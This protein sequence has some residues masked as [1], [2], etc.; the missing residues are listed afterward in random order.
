MSRSHSALGIALLIALS[1]VSVGS[2][3][4][5]PAEAGA[6]LVADSIV[7]DLVFQ[8]KYA[9]AAYCEVGRVSLTWTCVN[10]LCG[11]ETAGTKVLAVLEN[12]LRADNYGGFL[13]L[14]P[15]GTTAVFSL[16]GSQ[17]TTDWVLDAAILP[18]SNVQDIFPNAPAGST[19]HL[20]FWATFKAGLPS[21][22]YH[23]NTTLAKY[24]SVKNV[25]FTGHSLGAVQQ[26]LHAGY[27]SDQLAARNITLRTYSFAPARTVNAVLAAYLSTMP[28]YQDGAFYR[29]ITRQDLVPRI[30][31]PW[32]PTFWTHLGTEYFLNGFLGS[33]TTYKCPS[34]AVG[35]EN[36]YCMQAVSPLELSLVPGH[37]DYFG[38]DNFF[39]KCYVPLYGL[40]S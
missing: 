6:S 22:Q 8:A 15:G 33:K 35:A 10:Q 7:N 12:S 5:P 37:I 17:A 11:G 9:L 26:S 19:A 25:V 23:I 3:W 21:M 32:P 1:C 31:P 18:T 20:G 4:P 29:V 27:F 36:L 14:Q 13:A 30:L 34:P 16:A 40:L 39:L 28:A 2:A 24:P 38:L